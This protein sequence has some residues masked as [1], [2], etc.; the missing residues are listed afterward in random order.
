[1]ATNIKKQAPVQTLE[2]T[3]SGSA[4]SSGDVV[5]FTGFCGIALEDIAA[6][7]GVGTVNVGGCEAEVTAETGVAWS[8]GDKIYW[9]GSEATKTST[10]NTP[11]GICTVA[12][13]SATATGTVALLG[14][15]GANSADT[16]W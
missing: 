8:V 16:T 11:M 5:A 7:T 2:Y 1:M 14:I 12:K 15:G 3:N 10:S 4:I 6:T 13:A 9:D